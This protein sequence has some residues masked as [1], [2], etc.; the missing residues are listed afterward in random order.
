[1]QR[2]VGRCCC[3]WLL[4]QPQGNSSV[5]LQQQR[6]AEQVQPAVFMPGLARC[7]VEQVTARA[8]EQVQGVPVTLLASEQVAVCAVIQVQGVPVT[9]LDTAGLREAADVVE[10]VGVQRA[11]RA[12]ADADVVALVF[13]AQ[14][15]AY[16]TGGRQG[17]RQ[18]RCGG[19]SL[20]CTG[21]GT[22]A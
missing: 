17:C 6:S 14:V 2:S 7:A 5:Q 18:R 10:R 15:R 16:L 1:M 4:Q 13:D 8:G 22:L 20:W 21:G 3:A 11:A 12:A 19:P 9:L